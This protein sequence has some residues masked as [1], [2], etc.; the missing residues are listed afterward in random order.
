MA[1]RQRSS[2][3]RRPLSRQ[4]SITAS[5]GNG[6]ALGM[7]AGLAAGAGQGARQGR[8]LGEDDPLPVRKFNV[9]ADDPAVAL[10]DVF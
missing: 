3:T 4:Q 7:G 8:S 2:R 1:H 5:G 6:L 10:D 9:P